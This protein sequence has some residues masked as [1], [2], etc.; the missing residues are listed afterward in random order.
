MHYQMYSSLREG[1]KKNQ[2]NPRIAHFAIMLIVWQ[3][4]G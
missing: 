1:S 4:L 3:V 2:T